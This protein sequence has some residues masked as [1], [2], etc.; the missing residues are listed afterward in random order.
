MFLFSKQFLSPLHPNISTH[1]LH[2][3]L[4][5]FILTGADKDWR[6][7]PTIKSLSNVEDHF[8]YSHDINGYFLFFQTDSPV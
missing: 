8:F 7:F 5:T 6:I 3:V 1:I 2:T 4:C